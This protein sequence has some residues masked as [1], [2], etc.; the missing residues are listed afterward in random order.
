LVAEKFKNAVLDEQVQYIF[1]YITQPIPVLLRLV[2]G[3]GNYQYLLV[4]KV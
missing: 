3:I 2:K 4:K 1:T